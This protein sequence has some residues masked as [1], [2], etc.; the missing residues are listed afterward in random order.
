M[1]TKEIYELQQNSKLDDAVFIVNNSLFSTTLDR[2]YAL[3]YRNL[4]TKPGDEIQNVLFEIEIDI[5]Q[6]TRPFANISRI[7]EF[8]SESEILFMIGTC[9]II[10]SEAINYDERENIWIIKLQLYPNPPIQTNEDDYKTSN[11][12]VNLRRCMTSVPLTM[13]LG[14]NTTVLD[15]LCLMYPSEVD[16]MSA[17]RSN[18]LGVYQYYKLNEHTMAL[19]IIMNKRYKLG[20]IIQTMRN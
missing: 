14:F 4:Q 19:S 15:D 1:S 12:R 18:A 3:I 2:H 16:W 20:L 13:R 10:T 6:K 11:K 9:F 5:E 7:S 17:I 8:E